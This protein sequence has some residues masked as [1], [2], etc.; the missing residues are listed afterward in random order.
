MIPNEHG[1]NV[2][3]E[4]THGYLTYQF[5]YTSEP[6]EGVPHVRLRVKEFKGNGRVGSRT[7]GF[8]WPVK[9]AANPTELRDFV[10]R[11]LAATAP[12]ADR[13]NDRGVIGRFIDRL[14]GIEFITALDLAELAGPPC[15]KLLVEITR[16]K[17]GLLVTLIYR[18]KGH[19]PIWVVLPV[20]S[21]EALRRYLAK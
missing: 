18:Q 16:D 7:R 10:E 19:S 11:I 6:I 2:V 15:K 8:S 3:D 1:W 20:E 14:V 4:R 17:H 13:R 21:I 9:N 12:G 5:F